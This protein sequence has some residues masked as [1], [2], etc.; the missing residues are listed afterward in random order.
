VIQ[1]LPQLIEETNYLIL[2]RTINKKR[3]NTL[4]KIEKKKFNSKKV[5]KFTDNSDSM[6]KER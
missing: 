2:K 5:I 3:R 6:D 4:E 1:K